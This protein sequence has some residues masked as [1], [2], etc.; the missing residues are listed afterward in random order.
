MLLVKGA[1]AKP[2]LVTLRERHTQG[3]DTLFLLR[4]LSSFH[5]APFDKPRLIGGGEV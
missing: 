4:D 5:G 3:G 1:T 2:Q